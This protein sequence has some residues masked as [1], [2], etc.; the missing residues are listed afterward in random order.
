MTTSTAL[1]SRATVDDHLGRVAGG[2]EKVGLHGLGGDSR[3]GEHRLELGRHDERDGLSS[4][5][6][7]LWGPS[8]SRGNST[9]VT[10]TSV[11]PDSFASAMAR[12][13]ARFA[14]SLSSYPTT[15][16]LLMPAAS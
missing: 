6:P 15:I 9:T 7:K 14:G 5:A 10:T 3:V 1:R 8:G 4:S 16:V 12:S 2:P 11:P 13:R